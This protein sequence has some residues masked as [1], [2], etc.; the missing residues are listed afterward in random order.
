MSLELSRRMLVKSLT[1]AMATFLCIVPTLCRGWGGEGHQ[2][3]ALIAEE[4]LTPEA[5]AAVKDLLGSDN[6]S[7]AEVVNWADE[8]RRERRDT[9]P[10]HYV[11][12]PHDAN[13]YDAE[14]D[15]KKGANVID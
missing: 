5:R 14:R 11:N 12:I 15:G 1:A 4:R 9:A 8:V 3:I 7:D 6:L 2:L 10:W 13:A